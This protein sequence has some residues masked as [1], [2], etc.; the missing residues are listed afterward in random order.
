[1]IDMHPALIVLLS[2]AGGLLL[3][4]LVYLLILVRPR[5]KSP[6]NATLL[7][8]YAHRGLHGGEI[9]ENSLA[10]FEKACE[11]GFG[12]ELDVQLSR[13]GV[14]MVFHDYTLSRMTGREGK[15]K[16]LDAAELQTLSLNGTSETIPTFAE[17][18]A[19]VD[20]RVP[21]LVEL[22][23][24]NMDTSLCEKVASHLTAYKGAYCLESFNP[25]LIGKMGKY[26]PEAYRGLLYTNV[27]RD[28]K[29]YTPL[30]LIITAMLLNGVAKPHFIA[31]NC[32]DRGSLPV[33]L[34]TKLYSAPRFVWTVRDAEE[35]TRAH[36]LGEYAI[37][38]NLIHT[39]PKENI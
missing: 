14:V 36:E 2:V 39:D 31:C 37:F 6:E 27:C 33:S 7:C 25:L 28:K 32:K 3:V 9:P 20:G 16:E 38:E 26:L 21:L 30:N 24:E 4:G 12:I 15:L 19:L 22:K 17:V 13:D 1:M 10:A 34:T 11:A 8:D 29:K 35:F 18:L 23:G 5:A